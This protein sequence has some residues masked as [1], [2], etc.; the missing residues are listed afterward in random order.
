MT[1]IA[2]YTRISLDRTGDQTSTVRQEADCHKFADMRG[3]TIAEVYEDVDVSAYSEKVKRPRFEQL[4]EDLDAGLVDGVLVWK[5]DRLAR[6]PKDFL[7]VHE[8]CQRR[9]AILA[10]YNE[11]FDTSTAMG[12][13][14]VQMMVLIAELES[15]TISMRVKS[16]HE[17]HLAEGK[18]MGYGRRPFGLAT[19]GDGTTLN[20]EEAELIR[21]AAG[22]VLAGEGLRSIATDWNRRGVKTTAGNA[23]RATSVRN[24]LTGG[25]LVQI[26]DEATLSGLRATLRDPERVHDRLVE[27]H[28]LTGLVT[29][30]ECGSRLYSK[31]HQGRRRYACTR[32]PGTAYCGGLAIYAEPVEELV[33]EAAFYRLDSDE[34]RQ[35]LGRR[36]D[37]MDVLAQ[38]ERDERAL[39]ELREDYY[40]HRGTDLE[41]PADQFRRLERELAD[42]IKATREQV[43]RRLNGSLGDLGQVRE[44]WE[45]E[46]LAWRRK[47]LQ[48]LI[49]QVVIHK[50]GR[51]N[52]TG[53]AALARR[54][55]IEW[56]V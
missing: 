16:A 27:A 4:L 50:V 15:A 22:R 43:S 14:A 36:D 42:R 37:D 21:E 13:F 40:A 39:A 46:D 6:R 53:A 32:Q 28:L 45:T 24:V 20:E 26:L 9:D 34:F 51:G 8:I 30:G 18:W 29:C 52:R 47:L 12:K 17:H 55:S 44:R 33:R 2:I 49:R 11:Q 5:L 23:W 56:K 54:V 31:T 41:I 25:W 10:S 38:L 48:T 1:R 3:W 19:R 7:R 35:Q